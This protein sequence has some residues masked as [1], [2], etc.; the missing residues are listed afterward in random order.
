[1][2]EIILSKK[3]L[4]NKNFVIAL[5]NFDGLHRGH[6]ELI[7]S[8]IEMSEENDYISSV[9]MFNNHTK[10]TISFDPPDIITNNQQ[11]IEILKDLGI[12]EIFCFDFSTEIMRLSPE[13]FITDLLIDK[14]N[15]K[16]IVVG[17]DY[18]FGYK[19]QGDVKLLKKL[20][21]KYNLLLDI[22]DPVNFHNEPIS[23]TRIRKA[24]KN[25]NFLL[26]RELLDRHFTIRGEVIGGSQRG[27]DLG[28]PT[29]N[30]KYTNDYI[31]PSKGVYV[32]IVEFNKNFYPAVT[33]LGFNPTFN[34]DEFKIETYILDFN[35]DIYGEIIEIAF[36]DFIRED[37]KFDNI[38]SL[39]D[40][41][42]KDVEYAR[43]LIDEE[44]LS[45]TKKNKYD[46]I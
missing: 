46:N 1:M 16:G 8:V 7:R 43:K 25:N 14:L 12:E 37:K 30:L 28:F 22:V 32:T 36:L 35:Q 6:Q 19:A 26:T 24:I 15:V 18:R 11:K 29:A 27:K 2:E 13:E 40:Q 38:D 4:N 45:F 39:I 10:S 23:S 5:G 42:K 21:E 34:G 41:M 3:E 44:L 31:L 20:T 17:Y 9:L 33:N